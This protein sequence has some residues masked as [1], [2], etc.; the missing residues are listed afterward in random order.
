MSTQRFTVKRVEPADLISAAKT[1]PAHDARWC[2]WLAD[3]WLPA[4]RYLEWAQ[5]SI[6]QSDELSLSNAVTYAKRAVCRRLDG[7]VL[8]NHLHSL[9]R[10]SYREKTQALE[11]IGIPVSDIVHDLVIEPRNSVEHEYSLPTEGGARHAVQLAQLVLGATENEADRDS[12]VALNS[13]LLYRSETVAGRGT[14]VQ[15]TGF[16]DRPMLFLD[17]FEE[18]PEAKVVLPADQEIMLSE[19][20][21][22]S[23]DEAIELATAV[24]KHYSLPNTG[25]FK[26]PPG[27]L[28]ELKRQAGI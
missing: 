16:S 8:Y 6:G 4:E 19:L 7:L 27:E 20:D 18:R 12:I 1:I 28:I 13:N 15:F 9:I 3:R 10:N 2:Y 5:S 23:E 11:Q 26:G 24:R 17:V 21:L 25:G 22:F 14:S